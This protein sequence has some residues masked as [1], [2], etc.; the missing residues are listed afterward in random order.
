MI[1]DAFYSII[2]GD[3]A[4]DYEKYLR[5]SD[6]F[7]C[8]EDFKDLCNGDELQFQ[9]IHQVI[10]LFGKVIATTL[11]DIN[12]YTEK[13]DTNRIVSLFLRIHKMQKLILSTMDL[14][15][16]MSPKE[17]EVIRLKLGS[18]SGKDSP[19][20]KS[21][22]RIC[23]I[24]WKNYETVYLA[25]KNQTVDDI[26]DDKYKHCDAYVVAEVMLEFDALFQRFFHQHI[27]LV[28]RT[29]GMDAKS[30]RGNSVQML[31]KKL[32]LQLFPKLWEIRSII[33]N[34][35]GTQHGY[36]REPI[37]KNVK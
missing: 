26:Y 4:S 18:G 8:Q 35:W 2:Q 6:L 10:E 16:T 12:E 30:L 28:H 19:T 3:G 5:L 24:I 15:V 7:S 36:V 20:V 11:L 31:E 33:F 22:M 21:I 25:A 27:E 14:L 32:S 29:I 1:R 9:V 17:Y 23:P 37:D 34:K 13:S